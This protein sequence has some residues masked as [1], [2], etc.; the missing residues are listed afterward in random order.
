M[1][2]H[3]TVKQRNTAFIKP[4]SSSHLSSFRYKAHIRHTMNATAAPNSTMRYNENQAA[5]SLCIMS[6]NKAPSSPPP[7]ASSRPEAVLVSP[8]P[9]SPAAASPIPTALPSPHPVVQHL[10]PSPAVTKARVRNSKSPQQNGMVSIEEMARLM[11][12]VTFCKCN[13]VSFESTS[14]MMLTYIHNLC[15]TLS[16]AEYMVPPNLS[17]REPPPKPPQQKFY[18]SNEN[19]TVG[20]LTFPNDSSEHP[21]AGIARWLVT[22]QR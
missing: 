15:N 22:R 5:L 7:S 1:H 16:N 13:F 19:S 4:I 17:A 8:V 6:H 14:N 12:L 2:N 20:F 10:S 3:D 11:R 9:I 18:P 21:K